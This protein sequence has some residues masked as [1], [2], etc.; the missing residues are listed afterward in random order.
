MAVPKKRTSKSKKKT[1]RSNWNHSAFKESKKA[2]SLA[3]LL[4]KDQMYFSFK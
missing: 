4:F 3:K 1:H 2:L